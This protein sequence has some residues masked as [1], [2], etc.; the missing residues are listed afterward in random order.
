MDNYVDGYYQGFYPEDRWSREYKKPN[1]ECWIADVIKNDI[2]FQI[3]CNPTD[4]RGYRII[5]SIADEETKNMSTFNRKYSYNETIMLTHL[6]GVMKY[7]FSEFGLEGQVQ[8]AGNNS[9][10]LHRNTMYFGDIKEPSMLHGHIIG[11]GDPTYEYIGDVPLDGPQPGELFNMRGDVDETDIGN[12]NKVR[13]ASSKQMLTI[14]SLLGDKLCEV[15]GAEVF[16]DDCGIMMVTC[17]DIDYM[18]RS[19]T[20]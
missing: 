16:M 8:I 7:V 5:I 20:K 18:I 10:F 11:R 2:C 14:S 15:L 6:L 9:Q 17:N 19:S 1:M 4:K 3:F 12:K 13:W